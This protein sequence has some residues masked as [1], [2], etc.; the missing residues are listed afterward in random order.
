M[1][2]FI[3]LNGKYDSGNAIVTIQAGA[4]G[5][6]PEEWVTILTR[7]YIRWAEINCYEQQLIEEVRGEDGI[8]LRKVVF[9]IS[10]PDVYGYLRVESGV[11]RLTRKSPHDRK[12]RR[13]T[14]FALVSVMPQ[15]PDKGEKIPEWVEQVRSYIFHPYFQVKDLKTGLIGEDPYRVIDGFIQDFIDLRLL[16]GGNNYG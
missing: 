6:E 11:H 1:R 2:N 12:G 8:G 15:N 4:R 9:S 7:M 14:S 10:G 5:K 3:V 16:E 13:H